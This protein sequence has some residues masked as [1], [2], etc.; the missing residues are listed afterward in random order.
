[1][2][3]A[4]SLDCG[5]ISSLGTLVHGWL[6]P[7]HPELANNLLTGALFPGLS[8]LATSGLMVWGSRWRKL[9]LRDR[10]LDGLQLRG[11]EKVLD[12]GCGHGLLVIGAAK[13]VPRGKAVGIDIWQ[14]CDQADNRPNATRRNAE[15]EGVTD[16]VEVV[17]AD[18]RKLPFPDAA[19]DVIV[20]IWAL[21]NI[22]T[23]EGRTQA[24]EEI[25]RVLR[26]GGTAALLDIWH[27]RDYLRVLQDRGLVD[28]RRSLFSACFV[29]PTHLVLGRKGGAS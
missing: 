14:Q 3:G 21:H 26:P 29:C 24:V 9:R 27:T 8:W 28:L 25:A 11:D 15:I 23:R 20:S 7:S 6:H 17:E 16:R 13:R 18:A 12:V 10:L 4:L 22:P 19:F 2:H 5:A 1:M